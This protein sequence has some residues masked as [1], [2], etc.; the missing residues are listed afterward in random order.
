MKKSNKVIAL[1]LAMML[2]FSSL[3]L[4]ASASAIKDE[5]K[6]VESLIQPESL[7]DLVNWLLA[8]IN[9][10]KEEITGTVLRL[11]FMF[12]NDESLKAKI[13]ETDLMT[14]TDEQLAKI[15][16]DWLN[17][18]LPEWTKD[19]PQDILDTVKVLTLGRI[20]INLKTVD[21]VVSSLYSLANTNLFG[22]ISDLK[23]DALKN[24]SVS[25]SG[26][27]GVVH[28]LL[29]FLADNPQFFQKTLKGELNLG[30]LNDIVKSFFDINAEI[31]K[32]I[33]PEAIKAMLIDAVELDSGAPDYMIG[34]VEED[35]V[36]SS[37]DARLILR[38]AVGLEPDLTAK[39]IAAAECDGNTEAINSGDARM[40]LRVAVKLEEFP[41]ITIDYSKFTADEILAAAFLKLLTG[42]SAIDQAEANAVMQLSIYQFLETYAGDIYANL[43]LDL[44]NNDART[45]LTDLANKD[46]TGTIK[47]V[48]NL[49]YEFKEDTFDAYLGAGKGNMVAQLN[50]AV[51]TLL[52][53][54]LTKET[55][56]SLALETG[57]NSKLNGNLTKTFRFV[58]PLIKDIPGLGVDLSGFTTTEVQNKS[59]EE[60]AVA[61]LKLF[62]KGWFKLDDAKMAEVNKAKTL[63][64]LAVYAAYYA[65]SNK[66]W[67]PMT[68]TAADKAKNIET[69]SDEACLD[70][71]FEIGMETAAKAL[72]Y[73]KGTTYYT[74]PAGSESWTGADYLDDIVDWALN[75]IKGLPAVADTLSIERGVTDG[76]GGFYKINVILDSLFDLSFIKG[77][78]KDGFTVDVET[79]L[80]DKFLGNL[81]DFDIEASVAILA[82]NEDASIFNQKINEAAINLVDD[83]L[84]GLFE[85]P[86][87]A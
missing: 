41:E 70:L 54:V 20:S 65:V 66:E 10:R 8:S 13:G 47:K 49:E 78:G 60:L 53:V 64:Q 84:T 28:A 75:F 82:E 77:C 43:L 3:P 57:D 55:F 81:L 87:V 68:I 74:L 31:K 67:V 76:N 59:A 83:L 38:Y 51:I 46:T 5:V 4:I 62:F 30:G 2:A 7:A 27:L 85:V 52:Q 14:A 56:D 34:D 15:L 32:F 45:A 72:D 25:K 29:Q 16:V 79:M 71:V 26:N 18:N 6:T 42:K 73:N 9:N 23:E 44:L 39:Q 1:I 50:N 36:I 80:M 22:D 37:G 69:L 61:V 19:L 40:A 21:G 12:M 63:E 24:V 86:A 35:G 11:V 17:A 58:L 33:S 48:L